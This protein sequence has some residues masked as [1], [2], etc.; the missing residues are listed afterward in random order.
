MAPGQ[1]LDSIGPNEERYYATELDA[2]STA[3][4]SATVVPQPGAAVD[5]LEALHTR[6]AYG[7]DGICQ[8]TTEMF[9]Q[10]EGATPLTSGVSRLPAQSGTG[11][12]DQAGR[13]WLVVERKAAKGSDA[14][15][16]PMELTFHVEHPLKKGVT[17]AQS[18]PEYGA[19]GRPR[20]AWARCRS[21]GPT[22]TRAT[23]T[24]SPCTAR[25]TSTWR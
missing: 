6:I 5:D 15:R 21:P 16:W 22:V 24:S 23:R 7:T 12:C 2:A 1:Y 19:G 17:P 4:F 25:A 20:S 13:Y 3:N 10:Q 9:G 14:A 18:E 8:S 11:V